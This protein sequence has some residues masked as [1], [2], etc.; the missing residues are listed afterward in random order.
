[1]TV[2][3]W[4]PPPNWLAQVLDEM[5]EKIEQERQMRKITIEVSVRMKSDESFAAIVNALKSDIA[6]MKAMANILGDG[7]VSATMR[8]NTPYG[9]Y[10]VDTEEQEDWVVPA[11]YDDGN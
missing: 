1:M 5:E 7:G 11:L 3:Y 8:A 6:N 2:K 9:N 10:I 4:E